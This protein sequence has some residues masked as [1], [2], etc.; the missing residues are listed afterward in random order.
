MTTTELDPRNTSRNGRPVKSFTAAAATVERQDL[1]EGMRDAV[2]DLR[3][4]SLH[5]VID[6]YA[7]IGQRHAAAWRDGYY[8][9]LAQAELVAWDL[10]I[11][12]RT[13][14]PT[15]VR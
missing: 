8:T 7:T 10:F 3:E 14:Q 9:T 13:T 1:A 15:H 6:G 11:A 2:A 12:T 4:L 5:D